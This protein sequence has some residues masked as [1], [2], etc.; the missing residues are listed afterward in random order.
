M[1][2]G[3]KKSHQ[4]KAESSYL[5]KCKNTQKLSP[6]NAYACVIKTIPKPREIMSI[7]L[8][9]YLS[10]IKRQCDHSVI[11]SNVIL[12]QFYLQQVFFLV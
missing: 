1:K 3:V 11:S 7:K 10:L 4:A 6:S 9:Y 5:I 8:K 2:H 12:F